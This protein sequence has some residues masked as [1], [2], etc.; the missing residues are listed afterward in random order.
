MQ[1]SEEGTGYPGTDLYMFVS[2][3]VDAGKLAQVLQEQQ[4]SIINFWAISLA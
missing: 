2:H 3:H 1:R 4:Q